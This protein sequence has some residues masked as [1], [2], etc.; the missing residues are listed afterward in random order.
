MKLIEFDMKHIQ[1]KQAFPFHALSKK[2]QD[3]GEDLSS[4]LKGPR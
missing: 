4:T 2:S 1:P 3:L